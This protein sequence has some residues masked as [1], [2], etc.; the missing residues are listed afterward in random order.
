M[1]SQ[2]ICQTKPKVYTWEE[3][4]DFFSASEYYEKL[5]TT[6]GLKYSPNYKT[7]YLSLLVPLNSYETTVIG[8]TGMWSLVDGNNIYHLNNQILVYNDLEYMIKIKL[9][10]QTSDVPFQMQFELI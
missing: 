4:T 1:D 8:G 3:F 9:G 6:G 2:D 5:K 7:T 10:S